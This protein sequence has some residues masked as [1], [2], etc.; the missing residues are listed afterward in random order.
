LVQ[1]H[2]A[3]EEK[4]LPSYAEGATLRK[5][6]YNKY[7]VDSK[8]KKIVKNPLQELGGRTVMCKIAFYSTEPDDQPGL[9][10]PPVH[11]PM[12]T[13]KQDVSFL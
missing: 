2:I 13:V 11:L 4:A 1:F 12:S 5:I 10:L 3:Y 6:G 7:Y 8:H 9:L